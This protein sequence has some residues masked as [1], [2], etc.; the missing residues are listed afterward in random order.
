L[1][2]DFDVFVNMEY[3]VEDLLKNVVLNFNSLEINQSLTIEEAL[4]LTKDHFSK[5]FRIGIK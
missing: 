5:K 4:A 2:S 3:L 1:I